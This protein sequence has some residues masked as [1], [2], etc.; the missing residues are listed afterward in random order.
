ME[1]SEN[2]DRESAYERIFGGEPCENCKRKC[3]VGRLRLNPHLCPAC[4]IDQYKREK[5][6][7][8]V[9]QPCMACGLG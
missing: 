4:R 9:K 5:D 1:N 8:Q 3:P 7:K 2:E 6:S